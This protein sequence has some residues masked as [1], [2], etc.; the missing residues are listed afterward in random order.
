[1]YPLDKVK[2]I[3]VKTQKKIIKNWIPGKYIGLDESQSKYGS[4]YDKFSF[5][6]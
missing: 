1:M 2:H 3:V 6:C 5:R 4:R